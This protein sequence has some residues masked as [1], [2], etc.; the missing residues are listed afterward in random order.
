MSEWTRIREGPCATA[1]TRTNLTTLGSNATP[2]SLSVPDTASRVKRLWVAVGQETPTLAAHGGVVFVR[3]WG[4]AFSG[5][6]TFM[7]AGVSS[8]GTTAGE[9]CGEATNDCIAVDIPV[10]KKGGTFSIAAE[11]AGV[12]GAD[13]SVVVALIGE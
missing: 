2:G 6:S 1:D 13:Q 10:V 3:L 9:T 4:E 8:N 7:V 11:M 12:E 5:E